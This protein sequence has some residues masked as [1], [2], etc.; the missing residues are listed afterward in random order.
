[1]I[2]LRNKNTIY[3]QQ[4]NIPRKGEKIP[5]LKLKIKLIFLRSWGKR[6]CAH[7]EVLVYK[8]AARITDLIY[9]IQLPLN[10]CIIYNWVR[11]HTFEV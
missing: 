4:S 2:K 1:M 6:M 3:I 5:I 7:D 11:N 10:T 9:H 8:D